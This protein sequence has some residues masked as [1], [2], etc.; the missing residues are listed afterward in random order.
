MVRKCPDTQCDIQ[1]RARRYKIDAID[2]EDIW[3]DQG[4][5]CALCPAPVSLHTNDGF[6][7]IGQIDHCHSSGDVRGLLC[8]RCN[9]RVGF[10]EAMDPAWILRALAY[11]QG[12][13]PLDTPDRRPPGMSTSITRAPSDP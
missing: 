6:G 4:Y 11:A 2:L 13:R 8:A 1:R 10:L 7:P 9:V 3:F 12:S 5:R